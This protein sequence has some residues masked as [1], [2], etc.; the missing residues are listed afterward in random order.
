M[1]P[2]MQFKTQAIRNLRTGLID[3]KKRKARL[4]N[5]RHYN[6]DGLVEFAL[7]NNYI[8][9]AKQELAKGIVKGVVEAERAL[10]KMGNAVSID[11]WV[12]FEPR[13]KGSVDA[14]K[15]TLTAAKNQIIVG[16]TALKELKLALS[17][18]SFTCIDD[19]LKDD[20]GD[21]DPDAPVIA[22]AYSEGHE[23]DRE[24]IYYDAANA[25]YIVGE[26]LSGADVKITY[27]DSE[28]D[29]NVD[30]PADK[31]VTETDGISINGEWLAQTLPASLACDM[32]FT[33]TTPDGTAT[34]TL[35]HV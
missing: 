21:A 30:V 31:I 13:L 5:T 26:N 9:G 33:L 28:G 8:E 20:E 22:Y 34:V 25:L 14:E 29:M 15:R 11:G 10:V 6:L 23:D 12:K 4:A 1:K 3:T 32:T 35:K 24:N 2:T 7:G 16:V 27:F 19:D 17:D 18:F